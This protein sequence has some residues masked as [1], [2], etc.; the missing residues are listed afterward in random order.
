MAQTKIENKETSGVCK[1]CGKTSD[2]L[3]TPPLL[4]PPDWH[5][6]GVVGDDAK[7][8]PGHVENKYNL[9]FDDG[10]MYLRPQELPHDPVCWKCFAG[11]LVPAEWPF[12]VNTPGRFEF[13]AGIK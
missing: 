11:S 2:L 8:T 4:N 6:V 7:W 12:V 9:A 10:V 5:A 13:P 1:G 3:F